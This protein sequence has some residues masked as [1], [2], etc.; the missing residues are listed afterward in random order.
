MWQTRAQSKIDEEHQEAATLPIE[1]D[2]KLVTFRNVNDVCRMAASVF[3]NRREAHQTIAVDVLY[4]FMGKP[5]GSAINYSRLEYARNAAKKSKSGPYLVFEWENIDY[6]GFHDDDEQSRSLVEFRQ[7]LDVAVY[8]LTDQQREVITL[9][10]DGK[11]QK[12]I[13]EELGINHATVSSVKRNALVRLREL[14]QLQNM[15]QEAKKPRSQTQ[16]RSTQTQ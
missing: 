4:R 11:E 7:W 2:S 3:R 8:Y 5:V 15:R 13:A 1:A 14:S 10:I 12:E 6:S 9:L 16:R